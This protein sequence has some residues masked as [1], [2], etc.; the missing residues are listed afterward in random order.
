MPAITISGVLYAGTIF[1]LVSVRR[2]PVECKPVRI[3]IATI[4]VG[5][6]GTRNKMF[7][8]SKLR[9]KATW[10]LAPQATRDVLWSAFNSAAA[11]SFPFIHIDGV[12]YTVQFEEEGD[13]DESVAVTFPDGSRYYDITMTF[14]EI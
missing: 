12:T 13:Y 4:L 11:V 3:P 7:Y 1:D 8:G 2:A 9:F 10:S 6:D 5:R 14:H